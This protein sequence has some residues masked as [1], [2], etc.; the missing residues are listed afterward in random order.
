MVA[1]VEHRGRIAESFE[2]ARARVGRGR[3]LHPLGPALSVCSIC[4]VGMKRPEVGSVF[5][6][7]H[8]NRHLKGREADPGASANGHQRLERFG[9]VGAGYLGAG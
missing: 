4:A 2:G 8:Q 6:S 3:E 1:V 5:S 7:V 9:A